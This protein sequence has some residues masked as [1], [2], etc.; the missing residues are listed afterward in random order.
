MFADKFSKLIITTDVNLFKWK[1]I[2]NDL[3][4]YVNDLYHSNYTTYAPLVIEIS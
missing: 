2:R 3:L 1:A 4:E